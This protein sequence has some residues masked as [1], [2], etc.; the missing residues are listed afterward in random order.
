MTGSIGRRWRPVLSAVIGDGL[1]YLPRER[2]R[3]IPLARLDVQQKPLL[4][5]CAP[6]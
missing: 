2:R 5:G 6:Q 3:L 1:G 4:P